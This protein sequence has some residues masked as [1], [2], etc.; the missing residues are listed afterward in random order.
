MCNIP[1]N[2]FPERID[3]ERAEII[4]RIPEDE[5][6]SILG[7]NLKDE[8][9]KDIKTCNYVKNIRT[10]CRKFMLKKGE[11]EV[12]YKNSAK[13]VNIGRK[14]SK[15]FSAQNLE[16]SIRGYLFGKYY[17][18]FDMVNAAPS[19]LLHLMK[20]YYP[21]E[22]FST[23]GKYVKNRQRVFDMMRSMTPAQVK[24]KVITAMYSNKFQSSSNSFLVSLDREFKKAQELIYTK[25]NEFT[26]PLQHL[27]G[28]NKTNKQ[29]S[30]LSYVIYCL[31]DKILN[32]GVS[33]F[34]KKYISTLMYDGFHMKKSVDGETALSKLNEA[35]AEYGVKWSIK[36]PSMKLDYLDEKEFQEE[37]KEDIIGDYESVKAKFE[38][39]HFMIEAPLSFGR[40]TTYRGQETYHLY[41]LSEYS[42][43]VQTYMYEDLVNTNNGEVYVKKVKFLPKW[44]DDKNK[45]S[46]KQ[47]DFIPNEIV[48]DETYNTFQGFNCAKEYKYEEKPEVIELFTELVNVLT[49][50][51]A[52]SS[53]YLIS[54]IADMF[55]NTDRN[56][57]VAILFKS[58]QGYGKDTL[59]DLVMAMMGDSY[60]ARTDKIEDMLGKFNSRIKNKII[61][62]LNELEGKDGWEYRDKL[63]GIISS[64]T[65]SIKEEHMKPYDQ[66]FFSRIFIMSNRVNPI[67]VAQDDRRFCVFKAHYK[68]PSREFFNKIHQIPKCKDSLYTLYNYLM[69][70]P[71]EIKSWCD[72]RPMTTAYKNMKENNINPLYQYIKE[73]IVDEKIDDYMEKEDGA[74][75][76]QKKTGDLLISCDEFLQTYRNYLD[77]NDIMYK[78]NAKDLKKYLNEIDIQRERVC[79]KGIRKYFYKVDVND[80]K[81][82]IQSMNIEEDDVE[83][84]D[85]WE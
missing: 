26:E 63:K 8:E 74:Y 38:K 82:Q 83:L 47:I 41:K 54:Y 78:T 59:I 2:S 75:L 37:D 72:E 15:T 43:L 79:I 17:N 11:V 24:L 40:E 6:A 12:N 7:E 62:Q 55:Q 57:E 1:D 53:K 5:F 67:E 60:I 84:G 10:M 3:L 69:N 36:P 56:P 85:D 68:K 52:N 39:N 49:D 22:N 73:I 46:Y 32:I 16:C 4:A 25:P 23:L 71:I 21:E 66:A 45:R 65:V 19:I 81:K 13:L 27:K 14:Y 34:E 61:L 28:L 70:Y 77:V 18:D 48:S 31:E 33:L 9:G 20:S 44:L 35:T 51:E 58:K 80:T 29:G 64:K 76:R 42:T 30:F 50:H